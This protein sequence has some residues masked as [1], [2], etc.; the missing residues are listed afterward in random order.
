MAAPPDA[1]RVMLITRARASA[2]ISP[3]LHEA[4]HRLRLQPY[5]PRRRSQ[6]HAL[7]PRRGQ[8]ADVREMLREVRSRSQRLDVLVNN[9]GSRR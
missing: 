4:G 7:L 8:R 6:L 9:A 5:D 3:I 2:G 1:P